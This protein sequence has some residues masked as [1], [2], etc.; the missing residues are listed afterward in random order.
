M[1]TVSNDKDDQSTRIE[2]EIYEDGSRYVGEF[3]DGKYHGQGTRTYE[4]GSRYVGEWLDSKKNGRGTYINADGEKY[5]GE[6][7]C[8]KKNGGGT[9]NYVDGSKYI[10][11]WKD[12]LCNGGGTLT[13]ANGEEYAGEWKG[14]EYIHQGTM[15]APEAEKNVRIDQDVQEHVQG[16]STIENEQGILE[17]RIFLSSTFMDLNGERQYLMNKVFPVLAAKLRKRAVDL[18]VIDLRW[19]VQPEERV[20]EKGERVKINKNTLEVCLKE[21]ER[22]Y[23]LFIGIIGGRYG[24]IPESKDV[25]QETDFYKKYKEKFDRYLSQRKSMTEIEILFGALERESAPIDYQFYLGQE[26]TYQ[27]RV[28]NYAIYSKSEKEKKD[29]FEEAKFKQKALRDMLLQSKMAEGKSFA[30]AESLGEAVLRDMELL[31]KRL[32]QQGQIPRMDL[33]EKELKSLGIKSFE[34]QKM[35]GYILREAEKFLNQYLDL[36][37]AKTEQEEIPPFFL[38]GPSGTGK[39]TLIAKWSWHL[40]YIPDLKTIKIY[41]GVQNNIST[42]NDLIREILGAIKEYFSLE[43]D[44]PA[45]EELSN[46]FEIWLSYITEPTIIIIDGIDQL[47][48]YS[49]VMSWLPVSM[50]QLVGLIVTSNGSI[51]IGHKKTYVNE[52]RLAGFTSKEK[53]QFIDK[54]LL[55]VS[56]SISTEGKAALKERTDVLNN[57]PLFLSVILQELIRSGRRDIYTKD[58]I[59]QQKFPRDSVLGI[60]ASL[61]S[62]L[63]MEELFMKL[64]DRY[65][66]DYGSQLVEQML[67]LLALSRKGICYMELV[68]LVKE[69]QAGYLSGIEFQALFSILEDKLI[70]IG[71]N[72]AFYHAYLKNAVQKK[73]EGSETRY[74]E[75][76]ASYYTRIFERPAAEIGLHQAEELTWQLEQLNHWPALFEAI[77]NT[78]VLYWMLSQYM[79][80]IA[81]YFKHFKEIGCD[82]AVFY[83]KVKEAIKF[84]EELNNMAGKLFYLNGEYELSLKLME[85]QEEEL[86]QKY[87]EED[88]GLWTAWHNLG[89]AYR[90]KGEYDKAIGLLQKAA[91]K[92]EARYGEE[93]TELLIT[94]NSL[95]LAYYEKG[96]I[97]K[98]V[99]LFEKVAA[100]Q[101]DK[102]GDE[103]AGLRTTWNNL[104]LCYIEKGEI[105]KAIE[106]LQKA[107]E[108][109]ELKYGEDYPDLWTIWSNYAMACY[110]RGDFDRAI[111]L[112]E[113]VAAK[114]EEKYGEDHPDLW[115]TWNNLAQNYDD[116]GQPDKAIPLFEK[117]AAKVEYK[118]G[119]DYPDLWIIW[120][121][122]A[123]AYNEKG[124][125]DKAIGLLE[126]IAI[127]R[128][129]KFGGDYPGLWTIWSSLA[130][131]YRKKGEINKAE[132]LLQKLAEKKLNKFG[133]LTADYKEDLGIGLQ[134]YKLP[135]GS[136]YVGEFKYGVPYGQGTLNFANGDKYVGE[137][138]GGLMHGRGTYTFANGDRYVGEV[139]AGEI[140]GQGELTFAS[141]GVVCV[142]L[143]ENGELV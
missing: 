40:D 139:K 134:T 14:G 79:N 30:N 59:S 18:N 38:V 52:H 23:P 35:K 22:C 142:G 84:D 58:E 70:N 123:S 13:N 21:A 66:M 33:T 107:G 42:Q 127:K 3:K 34:N 55:Q 105:V 51:R 11:D 141:S 57:N 6:W 138:K 54:Y 17:I 109:E 106:L 88:P 49:R 46:Q 10:G 128:E 89:T 62:S 114:E 12:D 65:E 131:A 48:D 90:A 98:A 43:R 113:K 78:Q 19:G 82:Y 116:K 136:T 77:S 15:E 117:V 137:V 29:I 91:A 31:I 7:K 108:K 24:W 63:S 45:E 28:E 92:R 71:G 37:L 97:D 25:D 121:N 83:E 110:K 9:Y 72:F 26:D 69:E 81:G 119:E 101:E 50:Y 125:S 135:D 2:T 44:I 122:L 96:E 112:L 80:D 120:S 85:E 115:T 4:D 104:A 8:D 74:R 67:A 64:F 47:M 100:K 73:Y 61:A 27:D 39:S 76:L 132:T 41:I 68:D 111:E 103:Y 5:T 124:Q 118:Y 95:A 87:G 94:W 133:F 32:E 75:Q 93:S 99:S 143:F 20:S 53:E 129:A 130:A 56:K 102:Y 1:G 86:Q 16:T 60:I 140:T 126:K 36:L